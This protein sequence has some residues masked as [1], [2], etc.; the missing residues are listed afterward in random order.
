MGEFLSRI[1]LAKRAEPAPSAVVQ[2]L[3]PELE[4]PFDCALSQSAGQKACVKRALSPYL[5]PQID[6]LLGQLDVSA[7]ALFLTCYYTLLHRYTGQDAILIANVHGGLR[8]PKLMVLQSLESESF[9]DLARR[10]EWS[11]RSGKLATDCT[12]RFLQQDAG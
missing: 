6:S 1:G 5:Q 3:P 9:K 10:L 12:S 4:L 11:A 2:R 7:F 8:P